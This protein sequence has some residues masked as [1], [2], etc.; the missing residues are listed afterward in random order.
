MPCTIY[1]RDTWGRCSNCPLAPVAHEA[2]LGSTSPPWPS[3][4]IL[5]TSQSSQEE[6]AASSSR[7]EVVNTALQ[8]L[9]TTEADFT[10]SHYEMDRAVFDDLADLGLPEESSFAPTIV[11]QA[12]VEYCSDLNQNG[13]TAIFQENRAHLVPLLEDGWNKRSFKRIRDLEIFWPPEERQFI[14]NRPSKH[15]PAVAAEHKITQLAWKR[16][17]KGDA[18]DALWKHIVH[19]W[20]HAGRLWRDYAKFLA[21]V[22]S[23]G[24]G[25]SRL[26]DELSK[27]HLVIPMNWRDPKQPGFPACDRSLYHY[28]TQ[29]KFLSQAH[30]F[31]RALFMQAKK[32]VER[33]YQEGADQSSLPRRFREFMTEGQTM[34]SQGSKRKSFYNDVM[35][36]AKRMSIC[37]YR[38]ADEVPG[39]KAYWVQLEDAAQ[40]LTDGIYAEDKFKP[41]HFITP[42]FVLTFDEAQTLI[43]HEETRR[44]SSMAELR[45]TFHR[46]SSNGIPG[47]FV[48]LSTASKVDWF[49]R[50]ILPHVLGRIVLHSLPPF[51]DLSFD[52]FAF[53]NPLQEGGTLLD[54][55]SDEHM[56]TL[57][58]PLF[59][60]RYYPQ[61][62]DTEGKDEYDHSTQLMRS[63]IVEFAAQKLIGVEPG[64]VQ[65]FTED[66]KLACVSHRFPI[67]F[68]SGTFAGMGQQKRQVESHSRVALQLE[69]ESRTMES[70]GPSE[71]LLAEA[72]SSMMERFDGPM[73][74]RSI[75][76]GFAVD[77]G[78]RG[79]LAALLLLTLARDAAVKREFDAEASRARNRVFSVNTFLQCL[80]GLEEA[81]Y[82]CVR[83]DDVL[84]AGPSVFGTE[85]EAGCALKDAFAGAQMHFNH[86]IKVHDQKLLTR[87]FLV[88]FASR[89]IGV[90]F[91]KSQAGVDAFLPFTYRDNGRLKTDNMGVIL[92]QMKNDVRYTM[93]IREELFDAMNPYD[94]EL[95]SQESDAVVPVIRIVF[96]MA[97]KAPCLK[98]RPAVRPRFA[99]PVANKG[100]AKA[101]VDARTGQ[102]DEKNP[103]ENKEEQ[104]KFTAYEIWCSRRLLL[105]DLWSGDITQCHPLHSLA[106]H[107][108]PHLDTLT[109]VR[110]SI[111]FLLLL[112]LTG[113]A[114]F[115][116]IL[117]QFTTMTSKRRHEFSS[118]PD[119]IARRT[120]V[121]ED[122]ASDI[123]MASASSQASSGAVATGR[124]RAPDFVGATQ[125]TTVQSP[126]LTPSASRSILQ[127]SQEQEGASASRMEVIDDTL[128]TLGKTEADFMQSHDEM[129][130]KA[131]KSLTA[132]GFSVDGPFPNAN[133]MMVL[134]NVIL[135]C[136]ELNQDGE[137][138][139]DNFGTH[140]SCLIPLLEDGW[141]KRSFKHIRDLEILWPAPAKT[142]EQDRQVDN[143][144]MLSYKITQLAW[145]CDFKGNTVDAL[146]QHIVHHW[147]LKIE[148]GRKHYAKYL[149][150]VQ[151]S[152]M[153]KSRL[154]DQFSKDHLVIPMNLRSPHAE[155]FPAWDDS[156]YSYWSKEQEHP[157]VALMMSYAFLRALFLEA[158][159]VVQSIYEKNG[160]DP[161]SLPGHFRNFMTEGQTMQSQGQKRINFYQEVV[162]KAQ[163][164]RFQNENKVRS[165]VAGSPSKSFALDMEEG[166]YR[167]HLHQMLKLMDF[168]GKEG[169]SLRDAAEQ[170]TD[171]IYV[172]EKL[173]PA[174]FE[175][176]LF[177]LAF[178]EAH[179]LTT[180]THLRWWS[181]LTELRRALR[182]LSQGSKPAPVFAIFLSTTGKVSQ[183]TSASEDDPSHC[184]VIGV[185]SLIPPFT[186]LGFDQFALEEHSFWEGCTLLDVASNEHMARLGRP[187]FAT[188]YDPQ[189][190]VPTVKDAADARENQIQEVRQKIVDFAAEKLVGK[191]PYRTDLTEEQ[192]LA[193]LSHR[194]P[195]EFMSG[196]FT[197]MDQQKRQIESQ[198][199]GIRPQAEPPLISGLRIR[200]S[201]KT[202]K[203][204]P[205]WHAFWGVRFAKI[206]PDGGSGLPPNYP[207]SL[208]VVLRI[209]DEFRTMESVCPS[210]P[211]LAE[212]AWRMMKKFDAPTAMKSI[213]N[214]FAVD[215]GDW[216]ELVVLLLLIFARDAVTKKNFKEGHSEHR[217]RIISVNTFL[218]C[219]FG[220]EGATSGRIHCDNV[221]EAHPSIYRTKEEAGRSLKDAFAG[222]EMHFNHFI[223]VHDRKLLTRKYLM[224]LASRG[225]GVLC[226]NS[227]AGIDAF[228]PFTYCN[229]RLAR[230]NM[231]VILLQMKNDSRYSATI[232]EE[233]FG[234]INPQKPCL[235]VRPPVPPPEPVPP[236]SVPP[237]PVSNKGKAKADN[238]PQQLLFG[239]ITESSEAVWLSLR[240]PSRSWKKMYESAYHDHAELRTAQNPA[241]AAK[242]EIFSSWI[243]A[244]LLDSD[245]KGDKPK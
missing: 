208:H 242:P 142:P 82:G 32:V 204:C 136:K 146:W 209:D 152:G 229:S 16:D 3:A 124:L 154:V 237:Q 79:E 49:T 100:E 53:E 147:N 29:V 240:N 241:G 137:A 238:G 18:A 134:Q 55:A 93:T 141:K 232:K 33:L 7:M 20:D 226:G 214:G 186:D 244:T 215:Q 54:T 103:K 44:W 36:E 174:N 188:R 75:L 221:F 185:F 66:Q 88:F 129:D 148:L 179:T 73:A 104:K 52:Q 116:F 160:A 9:G 57:G 37:L 217:S 84:Q 19:H 166:K 151:S 38:N 120:K 239:P 183:F 162:R 128:K 200:P 111:I 95:F 224:F 138:L 198:G 222:A 8:T 170:L 245:H 176:P 118:P 203:F 123:D 169:N 51:T 30:A 207:G 191:D 133:A 12:I 110:S 115:N 90:L 223:K 76:N 74:M 194:L 23:S 47:F 87:K 5:S 86:F 34:E 119:H 155:G 99:S 1:D 190:Q 227:Q 25:K 122:P 131:F 132:G 21:I 85:E 178:D 167:S 64:R 61:S 157:D 149:A 234:A 140:T 236:Q 39:K 15:D 14:M 126:P 2:T 24:M 231:G 143:E 173:K 6:K 181:M 213:L 233:L 28:W 77:Q 161:S 121:T 108:H 195:I 187:L 117:F 67:D 243:P 175:E 109:A 45:N 199:N 96:A 205:D 70:V 127:F 182:A 125:D 168:L 220:S 112:R 91:S 35:Q 17:F 196:T 197:G 98:V 153:G 101:Q 211:L 219:L 62:K 68:M 92:L 60:T 41:A 4:P 135:F 106:I 59:S 158:K 107:G 105:I 159:K 228:I 230:D 113:R 81:T 212:A 27:T 189:P 40:R 48:F 218:E 102:P 206:R 97:G 63:N 156:L 10:Q 130:R 89:G 31:L 177:I 163:D 145:K 216:G 192:K 225:I 58:R 43:E 46:F 83:R 11:L 144:A 56:V 80:F 114:R 165:G 13:I 180:Q 202:S 69:G 72:A 201:S 235:K 65:D 171:A 71:P 94:L 22:Q 139:V 42:V 50:P 172:K 26:V 210:E 150:I 184:L 78:V 193:C 164:M